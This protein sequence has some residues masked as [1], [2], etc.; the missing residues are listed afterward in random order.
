MLIGLNYR[1]LIGWSRHIKLKDVFDQSLTKGWTSMWPKMLDIWRTTH[2]NEWMMVSC[3]SSYPAVSHR[4]LSHPPP[5]QTPLSVPST[6]H[7]LYC[8]IEGC[9]F[10]RYQNRQQ[11][12]EKHHRFTL[13]VVS[14]LP[15]LH[16][17][18]NWCYSCALCR[19]ANRSKLLLPN[20]SNKPLRKSRSTTAQV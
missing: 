3:Q 7:R 11:R 5:R 15:L 6:S 19:Y 4:D 18:C 13:T 16:R 2:R 14:S 10:S 12:I 9:Y 17:A 8:A 20:D 1:L